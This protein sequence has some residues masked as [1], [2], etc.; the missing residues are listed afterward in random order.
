MSITERN[1]RIVKYR[2]AGKKLAWIGRKYGITEAMA[3][4]IANGYKRSKRAKKAVVKTSDKYGWVT[5][6]GFAPLGNVDVLKGSR[7]DGLKPPEMAA[8]EG[9]PY[10]VQRIAREEIRSMLADKA[11]LATFVGVNS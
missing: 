7:P 9:I 2:Q 3:W 11:V 5:T 6:K 8:L 10:W 4:K 1:K